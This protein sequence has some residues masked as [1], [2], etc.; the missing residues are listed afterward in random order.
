MSTTLIE[1]N[2]NKKAEAKLKAKEAKAKTKALTQ[3]TETIRKLITKTDHLGSQGKYEI[4]G[5]CLD[6]LQ[7]D[8]KDK[9]YGT[10]AAKTLAD[11]LGWNKSEVYAYAR[12]VEAWPIE[13]D[14]N[15]RAARPD[16]FRKP[17]TWTHF[18]RI[19]SEKDAAKREQLF[20]KCLDNGWSVRGLNQH[21]L[22]ISGSHHAAEGA[23]S[24]SKPLTGLS[25]VIH[26]YGSQVAAFKQRTG[27]FGQCLTA[28]IS[29]VD[30]SDF[31]DESLDELLAVRGN[32]K[33]LIDQFDATIGQFTER[34]KS[35]PVVVNQAA[36][37]D[38]GSSIDATN[39]PVA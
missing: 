37:P 26:S 14:F 17:L 27:K 23:N 39:Q 3:K 5:H 18:R 13:A 12:V 24:E 31:N 30:P 10:N 22:G 6:V 15:E 28:K 38:A 25:A 8:G 19:A 7:G 21:M 9:M 11:Q 29:S 4:A 2:S 16:K 36:V 32:L 33:E 35:A 20:Q 1:K 34:R